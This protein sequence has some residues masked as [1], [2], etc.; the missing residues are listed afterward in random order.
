VEVEFLQSR[1]VNLI[2]VD[3]TPLACRAGKMAGVKVLLL[4][5]F[6]WD[7]IY[8]ELLLELI[9]KRCETDTIDNTT[10]TEIS[11]EKFERL[12]LMIDQCTSDYN[13]A[14][15]YA[16]LPGNSPPPNGFKGDNLIYTSLIARTFKRS[17]EEI[18]NTFELPKESKVL[19]LGFGGHQTEWNL[20][21]EFLP[22]D[23]TCLVL[24]ISMFVFDLISVI[25]N[26]DF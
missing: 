4:T 12:N 19:L 16:Q 14:N 21:D 11:E 5:N 6:T 15:V 10:K 20:K 24:G 26:T 22:K 7:F 17:K 13:D 1:N 3:A 18:K 23:W 9:S 25:C 2:I 8:R